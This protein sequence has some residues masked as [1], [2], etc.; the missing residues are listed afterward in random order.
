MEFQDRWRSPNAPCLLPGAH[1]WDPAGAPSVRRC[2]CPARDTVVA[3]HGAGAPGAEPQHLTGSCSLWEI[4]RPGTQTQPQPRILFQRETILWFIQFTKCFLLKAGVKNPYYFKNLLLILIP[5]SW[6]LWCRKVL[7]H[8]S[9]SQVLGSI[10]S[11]AEVS[12]AEF[13]TPAAI[14]DRRQRSVQAGG[15]RQ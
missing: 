14:L 12:D 4:N 10:S 7:L 13:L 1:P 2:T 5:P 9:P 8:A 6:M 11:S 15:R 3:L